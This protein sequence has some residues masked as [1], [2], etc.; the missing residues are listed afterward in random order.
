M[1]RD[2]QKKHLVCKTQ[3]IRFR[4]PASEEEVTFLLKPWTRRYEGALRK[5]VL[6]LPMYL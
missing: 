2:S 6:T 4:K 1:Y 3:R 5:E